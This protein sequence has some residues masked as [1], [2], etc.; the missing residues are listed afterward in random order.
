MDGGKRRRSHRWPVVPRWP[1]GSPW[2]PRTRPA[3]IVAAAR[4]RGKAPPRR[5]AQACA[6]YGKALKRTPTVVRLL[7][8]EMRPRGVFRPKHPMEI[9]FHPKASFRVKNGVETCH[10]VAKKA[11][12]G[13][14]AAGPLML[15]FESQTFLIFAYLRARERALENNR[16]SML[17]NSGFRRGGFPAAHTMRMACRRKRMSVRGCR[18]ELWAAG[19]PPLLSHPGGERRDS[20]RLYAADIQ[21]RGHTSHTTGVST[22]RACGPKGAD[23]SV[24]SGGA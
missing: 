4:R 24:A 5:Q 14:P 19:K 17:K 8:L 10:I 12:S 9:D 13:V 7:A 11:F 20:S 6:P 21:P 18:P 16:F 23:L 3:A 22:R 2:P 15:V 1:E